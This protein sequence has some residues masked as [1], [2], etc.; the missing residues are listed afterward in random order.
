MPLTTVQLATAAALC[1]LTAPLVSPLPQDVPVS[2]W[3]SIAYLSLMCTGVCYF[4]QALG[5]KYTSPQTASIILTLESV[6]GTLFSVVFYHERLSLKTVSGF[7][8]IFAAILISETK[9]SFL[10][11]REEAK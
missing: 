10:R 5:Q 9:L 4:L 2:A 6:F 3:L 8:L 1:W 11:G 7:A